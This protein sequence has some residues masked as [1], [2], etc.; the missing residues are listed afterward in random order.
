MSISNFKLLLAAILIVVLAPSCKDDDG[1]SGN[2]CSS[3]FDQAA[4]LTDY[5]DNLII[6]A[7]NEL[8]TDITALQQASTQFLDT[9]DQSTLAALK[10]AIENGYASYVAKEMLQFGPAEDVD[11]RNIMNPF[12]VNTQLVEELLTTLPDNYVYS[13]DRGFPALEYL[14]FADRSDDDIINLFDDNTA[15]NVART[16]LSNIVAQMFEAT[17]TVQSSWNGNYRAAFIANT[18]TAAGSSVS[19]LI[20][21]LNEHWER[22]KRDRLGI[23]SGVTTLGITNPNTVEARFM[24]R[25]LAFLKSSIVNNKAMFNAGLDDYLNEINAT[26][27]GESLVTLINNQY[28]LAQTA[29]EALPTPLTTTVNEMSAAVSD[30]YAKMVQNIVLLKT[31]MPSVLCVAITYV[32]NPSDSD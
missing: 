14:F 7:T 6:P 13:F 4:M 29:V 24:G 11:L 17:T 18:G 21:S 31:D 3:S 28:T 27:Q 20:N 15:D 1:G 32:D 30:A 22:S 23:P 5:A 26:K 25:S 10:T 2:A 19:L 8:L 16:Y 12:P 9:P